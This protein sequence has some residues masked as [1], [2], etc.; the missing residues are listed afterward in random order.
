MVARLLK[1]YHIPLITAG[2]V[3]YDYT[4]PKTHNSSQFYMLTKSGDSYEYMVKAI[5]DFFKM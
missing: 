3:T 2:G 4:K 1:V 5:Y